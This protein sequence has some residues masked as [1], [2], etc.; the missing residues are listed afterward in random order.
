[1]DWT[2]RGSNPGRGRRVLSFPKRPDRLWEPASLLCIVYWGW[3]L[4]SFGILRSVDWWFRIDVSV[5]PIG[6][7]FKGQVVALTVAGAWN[8]VS[9]WVSLPEIKRPWRDVEHSPPLTPSWCRETSKHRK[10]HYVATRATHIIQ[11]LLQFLEHGGNSDVTFSCSLGLTLQLTRL[12]HEQGASPTCLYG[13]R[14]YCQSGLINCHAEESSYYHTRHKI[15]ENPL[16]QF[17]C[18]YQSHLQECTGIIPQIKPRPF[19]STYL[20]ICYSLITYISFEIGLGFTL[21]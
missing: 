13:R 19:P 8:I 2:V 11:L 18:Y 7:I 12:L 6:S 15:H 21:S 9:Y 4:H 14:G 17:S 3:D 10:K 16:P 20:T 1:M 5:Q